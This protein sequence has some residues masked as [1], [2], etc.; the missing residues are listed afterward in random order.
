M[1]E[2]AWSAVLGVFRVGFLRSLLLASVAVAVAVPLADRFLVYPQFSEFAVRDTED[3]AIRVGRHVSSALPMGAGGLGEESITPD[4]VGEARLIQ[5]TIGLMKLKVF[6]PSG[7]VLFSTSDRDIGE[8]NRPPYFLDR[9]A[10]GD[11]HTKVVRRSGKSLEGQIVDVDVVET[12][13]PVMVDGRFGG[14]L[15]IYY[16]VTARLERLDGLLFYSSL[17]LALMTG[18]FLVVIVWTLG[19]AAAEVS[20]RGRVE[21]VLRG[22][23]ERYRSLVDLSPDAIFVQTNNG[24]TLTNPAM[25][26]LLGVEE[27]RAVLSM[28]FS[29]FAVPEDRH[30]VAAVIEAAIRGR[31]AYTEFRE[32]R[33]RRKDG[34][35]L[36]VEFAAFA[37][38]DGDQSVAQVI[39]HDLTARKEAERY[40]RMASIVFEASAEAM[41]ATD[42]GNRIE[43]VNPAFTEITGYSADE[44]IGKDPG[45]LASGRHSEDFYKEMYLSLQRDGFWRGNIWNR[46]KNGEPFVQRLTI[47]AIKDGNGEISKFVSVFSDITE[48][49]LEEEKVRNR[50]NMDAL[51]GLPNRYL[52]KTRLSYAVK[53]Q[54]TRPS[55]L[56]VLF[57]DLDGFKPVNDSY[58]HKAGDDVLQQVSDRLTACVRENDTVARLGGDEFVIVL[59]YIDDRNHVEMVTRKVMQSFADPF[60]IEGGAVVIGCSIGISRYPDDGTDAEELLEHAD[61]AMYQ[62]KHEGK[63]GYRFFSGGVATQA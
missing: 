10:K 23:E 41:M 39:V 40:H 61:Q 24:I 35:I 60:E 45:L 22:N 38:D 16:D 25:V 5:Q 31:E 46:R 59:R 9:V 21:K 51:T 50:A 27:P 18:V 8:V 11:V 36:D 49:K 2:R 30:Y 52:L 33:L 7:K 4:F 20:E 29:D 54:R 32:A 26:D 3:E 44:V 57:L 12:Y 42:A 14:A 6:A 55:N 53:D 13:I 48:E 62:A 19:R 63:G 37:A 17:A 1:M 34:S 58:G 43:M 56:A 28:D 47:S 15:E